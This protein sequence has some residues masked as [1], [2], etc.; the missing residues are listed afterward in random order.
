[1][2][3]DKKNF[4]FVTPQSNFSNN[5]ELI[6]NK[7]HFHPNSKFTGPIAIWIKIS[8]PEPKGG[9]TLACGGGGGGSQ[10]G[11]LEKKPSTLS[12][13]CP[14]WAA[15]SSY[16]TLAPVTEENGLARQCTA[17]I[18]LSYYFSYFFAVNIPRKRFRFY[19]QDTWMYCTV[20]AVIS[21][22]RIDIKG[23]S[24]E[25]DFKNFDKKLHNLA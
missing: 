23:L 12:T 4:S 20:C 7:N 15:L 14:L 25:I 5:N 18:I 1:M 13:L 8:H 9:D 17:G 3:V 16:Q 6:F 22:I 21:Y 24:H 2:I 10:F 19:F 11:R